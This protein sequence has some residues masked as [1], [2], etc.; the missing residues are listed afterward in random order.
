MCFTCHNLRSAYE[1]PKNTCLEE[2]DVKEDLSY[3]KYPIKI[4]D[5]TK[6]VTRSKVI[7]MYKV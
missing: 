4:L 5:T 2:L 1:C 3:T 6:R 7:R